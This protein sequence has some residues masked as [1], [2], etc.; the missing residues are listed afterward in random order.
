[1][2]RQLCP[3]AILFIWKKPLITNGYDMRLSESQSH[4]DR[5]KKRTLSAPAENQTP[6]AQF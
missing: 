3:P 4:L 1:M 6:T 2:A 5:L